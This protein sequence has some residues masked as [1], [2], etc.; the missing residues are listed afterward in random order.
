MSYN[1]PQVTQLES[2]EMSLSLVLRMPDP[3]P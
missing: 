2:A 3:A 1:F